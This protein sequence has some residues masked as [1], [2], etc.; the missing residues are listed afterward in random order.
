MERHLS[1]PSFRRHHPTQAIG[2]FLVGVLVL[3]LICHTYLPRSYM[4]LQFNK[5]RQC[6]VGG[7]A[8]AIQI[9]GD[10]VAAGGILTTFL[11]CDGK[12]IRNDALVG[13]GPAFSYFLLKDEIAAHRNPAYLILAYSPHT[14]SG[15]RTPVFIG[16]FAYWSELPELFWNSDDRFSFLYGILTRLS[17][18]LAYRDQFK[19]LLTNGDYHFFISKPDTDKSEK[20][21]LNE[22]KA[23]L[24]KNK[25]KPK[26]LGDGLWDMYK[27]PFRVSPLNDL[28]FCRL[29]QLT[30]SHGIK[31]YWITMPVTQRVHNYRQGISYESNFINYLDRFV[32]RGELKYIQR[33]FLVYEDKY[34]DDLSHINMNGAIKFSSRLSEILPAEVQ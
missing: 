19:A 30:K 22:Y 26:S 25:F 14:F 12:T 1:I 21:R 4:E 29:L 24:D 20:N 31:V 28:Y 23:L 5:I 17:Y 11:G 13:S 3:E 33:D 27:E 8:P 15:I 10:S 16:S 18:I 34:F 9:M 7:S 6:V 32:K 2:L